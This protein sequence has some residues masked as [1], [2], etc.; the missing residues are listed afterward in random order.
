MGNTHGY[1]N[2]LEGKYFSPIG[3]FWEFHTWMSQEVSKWMIIYLQNLWCIF[4]WVMYRTFVEEFL[5][6]DSIEMIL[7]TRPFP[8]PPPKKK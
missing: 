5:E 1:V 4:I 3:F 2:L 8:T 6:D 7:V